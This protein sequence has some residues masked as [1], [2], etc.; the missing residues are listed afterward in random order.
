MKRA[1]RT[2]HARM[3]RSYAR[4]GRGSSPALLPEEQELL[5]LAVGTPMQDRAD[6]SR[7]E[8]EAQPRF[9][10]TST[11]AD[12]LNLHAR[13]GAER[14]KVT[15]GGGKRASVMYLLKSAPSFVRST[16]PCCSCR[17]R[18]RATSAAGGP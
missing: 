13:R 1:A 10:R 4:Q 5:H 18:S 16:V 7:L 9:L 3:G 6:V 12:V 17:N 2:G 8:V 15:R 11:L 14:R